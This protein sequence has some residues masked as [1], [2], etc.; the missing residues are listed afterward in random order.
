L[1]RKE[2]LAFIKIDVKHSTHLARALEPDN[3]QSPPHITVA[4]KPLEGSLECRIR[5][6]GC[7]DPK[8]ILTLRNTVDDIL[9]AIRSG[10]DALELE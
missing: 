4:C 2:C 10:M 5:V 8:R 1:R 6:K 9:I 7:D 3:R